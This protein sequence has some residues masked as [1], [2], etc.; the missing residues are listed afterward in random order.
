[1]GSQLTIPDAEQFDTDDPRSLAEQLGIDAKYEPVIW[2]RGSGYGTLVKA[3]AEMKYPLNVTSEDTGH[4]TLTIKGQRRAQQFPD[5]SGVYE[6]Q[7]GGRLYAIRTPND[8]YIWNDEPHVEAWPYEAKEMEERVDTYQVPFDFVAEVLTQQTDLDMHDEDT[9]LARGRRQ[10]ENWVDGEMFMRGIRRAYLLEDDSGEDGVLL[11]HQNGVQL[12]VG[13]DSTTHDEGEMF[14]F[15]TFDGDDG[16]RAPTASDALDLLRPD[17]ALDTEER[18]GE[19]FLIESEDTGEGRIQRPGVGSRPFGAS[20]LDNH[21][22][23]EW[24]TGCTGGEFLRRVRREIEEDLGH[25][26][27]QGVFEK[28]RDDDLDL[29]YER[30]R[31]LADGIYVRGTLRHRD[32]EHSM[33][34]V[35]G[36]RKATTHDWDVI[37]M[38]GGSQTYRMD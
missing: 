21:V 28:I 4:G 35:D 11:N 8:V 33:A 26:S 15:V 18:Q 31:E 14:G 17:E 36:W 34:K 2:E 25:V 23:R 10:E 37:V 3:W 12:Y 13:R 16:V 27:P 19:W 29:S 38:D 5:G 1:M 7:R 9:M 22:P 24:R 6:S 32:N 20:P 30:A